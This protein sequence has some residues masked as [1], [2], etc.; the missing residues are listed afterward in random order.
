[1]TQDLP[2]GS[3]NTPR[4]LEHKWIST[5]FTIFATI[6]CFSN[7]VTISPG[8]QVC[9]IT[10]ATG[11]PAYK[12]TGSIGTIGECPTYTRQ[13]LMAIKDMIKLDTRYSKVPFKTIQ[14]VR[15]YRLNKR[16]IKLDLKHKPINQTR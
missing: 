1:M 5:I 4:L 8:S 6:M 2:K 7:L 10:S 16:P 12:A 3:M 9:P 15:K 14:L 13:Q 11:S